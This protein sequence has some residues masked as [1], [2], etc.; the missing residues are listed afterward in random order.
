MII[1][2]VS[3]SLQA[4]KGGDGGA[5]FS[6]RGRVRAA[7]GG[8]GGNGGD[9]VFAADPNLYDLSKFRKSKRYKAPGGTNGAS[10]RKHG[11]DG[12]HLRLHVPCGTI[13]RDK[14]ERL[15]ADL[16]GSDDRFVALGGGRGGY[17]NAQRG[18]SE[19][20]QPGEEKEIILDYRIPNDVAFLG[21]AN[22]GKTSLVNALSGQNYP[23]AAYPFTTAHCRWAVCEHAFKRFTVLDTPPVTARDDLREAAFFKH[24]YRTRIIVIVGDA[25]D[26][27]PSQRRTVE[28]KIAQF[29]A[30]YRKKKFF[31]LCTKVDTIKGDFTSGQ[32]LP[33]SVKKPET[34]DQLIALILKEMYP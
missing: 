1:D 18:Y 3:V 32:W 24:L 25:P 10:Q 15:L 19:C 13:I 4:G 12:E 33:V 22:T 17:G 28:S 16:A 23:V 20:G 14:D 27:L 8:D 9:V 34:I 7:D 30:R 5:S 21:F 6:R 31:Y 26:R 11:A 2:R 29:D